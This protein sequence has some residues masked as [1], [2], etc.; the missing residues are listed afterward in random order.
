MGLARR[1]LDDLRRLW[2]PGDTG[3]E[4]RA[5]VQAGNEG[6]AGLE[7]VLEKNEVDRRRVRDGIGTVEAGHRQAGLLRE[8][9]NKEL[10]LREGSRRDPFALQVVDATHLFAHDQAR[11]P[12][13]PS[14]LHGNGR[15]PLP[16]VVGQHVDRRRR[17]RDT[18]LLQVVPAVLFTQGDLQLEAA[19]SREPRSLVWL[20]SVVGKNEPGVTRVFGEIQHHRVGLH[21][22]RLRCAQFRSGTGDDKGE[23]LALIRGRF[24]RPVRNGSAIRSPGVR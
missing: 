4:V 10:R 13:R 23:V 15:L 20:E 1:L 6:I 11:G 18:P 5:A 17:G 22:G 3:R 9:A 24:R 16:T 8:V 12:S 2:R 19:V 7:G 21:A 14:D